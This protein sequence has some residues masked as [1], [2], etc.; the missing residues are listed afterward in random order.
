MGICPRWQPAIVVIVTDIMIVVVVY[1]AN[2]LSI[3][4]HISYFCHFLAAFYSRRCS[5]G[6]S[7]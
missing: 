4:I 6:T 7:R 1:F 3:Y 2:K 5:L